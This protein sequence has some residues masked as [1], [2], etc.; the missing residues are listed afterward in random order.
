MAIR[1]PK[2]KPTALKMIAGNPGRRPLNLSEPQPGAIGEPHYKLPRAAKRKW[3]ELCQDHV[4]GQV[5]TAADRD[6]LEHYCRLHARL[7]QAEAMV[8]EHGLLVTS[9]NGFPVQSPYVAIANRCRADLIKVA[10]ELGGTPSSRSR[11]SVPHR[12][13]RDNP[14]ARFGRLPG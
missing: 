14:F 7:L 6:I 4:W 12:P 10:I 9:P 5:L 13:R 1:G 2:P 11:L 3:R 8:D